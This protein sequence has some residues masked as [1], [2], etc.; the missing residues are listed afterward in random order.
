MI[1]GGILVVTQARS[2]AGLNPTVIGGAVLV[3]IGA[4]LL[5]AT[6]WGRGAGLVALGTTVALMI[7]AGMMLGG[8]P[9]KIGD[10]DWTPMSVAESSRSYD[11]GVGDGRLDLTEVELPPGSRTEFNASVSVGELTVIVPPSAR[12]EVHAKAKVGD[13]TID[14]SLR[15]GVDVEF[16]KVLAPDPAPEG[17][18]ATIVLN[19]KGGVG[20]VEVRRGA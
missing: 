12:V 19:I 11:V 9:T 4:G 3:T 20:D 6:W 1:V 15:G 5:V 7:A 16:D 17:K 13:I 18:A 2:A 10:F 14:Q 8:L